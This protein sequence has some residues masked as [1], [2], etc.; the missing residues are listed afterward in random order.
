[1]VPFEHPSFEAVIFVPLSWFDY[2]TAFRIFQV[3][4]VLILLA[5][6]FAADPLFGDDKI[7][8]PVNPRFVLL[9]LTFLPFCG[10]FAQQ[11]DSLVALA[12]LCL[13]WLGLKRGNDVQAG[14]LLSLAVF[15]FPVVLPAGF[16]LCVRKGKRFSAGFA[17]GSVAM[18]FLSVALIGKA[19]LGEYVRI[20][21]QAANGD[22][23]DASTALTWS[24]HPLEMPNISGFV[25][26]VAH[27]VSAFREQQPV[28]A[29]TLFLIVAAVS[30]VV[31]AISGFMVSRNHLD[32]RTAFGVAVLCG[33]LVSNHLYIHDIVLLSLPIGLLGHKHPVNV[34]ALY[35]LAPILLFAGFR[36]AFGL[37]AIPITLL[38]FA[39]WR[40]S[41]SAEML[42]EA[43]C[44]SR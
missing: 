29:H 7:P 21:H 6:L 14:L 8:F 44:F 18:G 1:M 19:G 17:V 33:I 22:K 11:Q 38:L 25:N 39:A 35:L 5:L 15:K 40:D 34:A 42:L 41:R 27:Q 10:A 30:L 36:E 26:F 32:D 13:S 2:M 23:P 3:V 24:E 20:L 31:L 28:P 12:L 4:N 9:A 37:I 16:L 43:P